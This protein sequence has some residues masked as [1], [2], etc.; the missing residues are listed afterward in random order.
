MLRWLVRLLVLGAIVVVAA[1]VVSRLTN[2]EEDFDD[3][4]DLDAGFDFQETL[5]EIEVPAEQYA[6]AGSRSSQT[7]GGGGASPA[8]GAGSDSGSDSGAN[9]NA[10]ASSSGNGS[11]TASMETRRLSISENLIDIVGIGPAF[12]ARLK[13]IGVNNLSDLA[14]A[15][16]NSL[17]EH[18]D[19]IG[20][21]AT[22]EDWIAQA[23]SMTSGETSNG[24]VQ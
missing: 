8:T 7:G 15:D 22:I 17:S 24:N 11:S 2:R 20:G 3:Y 4:D 16:A 19:V 12:D 18:L 10:H 5:V 23:K 13:A 6:G 14:R 21:V 9:A 1:M